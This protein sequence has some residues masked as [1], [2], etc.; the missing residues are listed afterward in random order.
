[1]SIITEINFNNINLLQNFLDN[2]L[3][4]TFRYFTKRNMD[5]IKNHLLTVILTYDNMS[6]GYAHIDY[7]DNKYWFGI[8]ILNNFQSK[9]FGKMLIEYILN[10]DAIKNINEIYLTVDKI[11]EKAIKLYEKY[12]FNKIKEYETYFLMIKSNF[13]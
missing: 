1:M 2:E 11:N 13:N 9:G 6:I 7:D 4:P 10:H 5:C 12:N 8:C 3:P